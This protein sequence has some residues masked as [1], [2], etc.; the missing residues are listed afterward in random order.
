LYTEKLLKG[1]KVEGI[2]VGGWVIATAYFGTGE[3]VR[4]LAFMGQVI[5]DTRF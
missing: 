2:D 3:D 1:I 5:D 4:R